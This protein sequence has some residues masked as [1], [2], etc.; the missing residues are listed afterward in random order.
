M[1]ETSG[2]GSGEPWG[3]LGKAVQATSG[4]W[5]S[6]SHEKHGLRLQKTCFLLGKTRLLMGHVGPL[7]VFNYISDISCRPWGS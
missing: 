2:V 6:V 4:P 7:V 5:P 1:E 3:A